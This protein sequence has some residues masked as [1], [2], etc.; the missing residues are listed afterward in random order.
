MVLPLRGEVPE[1]RRGSDQLS[2][3]YLV[4]NLFQDPANSS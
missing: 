4:L 2:P 1:G 3:I